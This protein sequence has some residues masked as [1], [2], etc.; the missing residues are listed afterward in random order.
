MNLYRSLNII[1]FEIFI[2][3]HINLIYFGF[4]ARIE[5]FKFF[6]I[7]KFYKLAILGGYINPN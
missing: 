6:E 1:N 3:R 5:I 4:I 7:F 2:D